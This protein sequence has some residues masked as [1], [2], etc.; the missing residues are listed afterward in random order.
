MIS[1]EFLSILSFKS[2]NFKFF[3]LVR[4]YYFIVFSFFFRSFFVSLFYDLD[5][6]TKSSCSSDLLE[7]KNTVKIEENSANIESTS[8]ETKSQSPSASNLNVHSKFGTNN[9]KAESL[10]KSN[11]KSNLHTFANRPIK[12]HS[13][14]SETPDVRHMETALLKMLDDF[15]HG[16][17]K[18]FG[19]K[20]L[21]FS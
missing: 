15:H 3:F 12:H 10:N 20:F 21:N 1:F 4:F 18:A 5:D 13:F 16:K 7:V 11:S 19:K 2:H 6:D 8:R 17:L 9:V 14:I